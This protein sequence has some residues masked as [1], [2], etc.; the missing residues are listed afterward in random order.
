MC[1]YIHVHI[2]MQWIIW[3]I[4]AKSLELQEVSFQGQDAGVD[5]C[6]S[7]MQNK[8]QKLV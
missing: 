8:N 3:N 6:I 2:C 1:I 5:L 4:L 7:F